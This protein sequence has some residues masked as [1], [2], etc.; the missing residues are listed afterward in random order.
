MEEA[1]ALEI[2]RATR[3]GA[4]LSLV[5]C[6]VDHFKRFND[7]FGHDAGDAVLQAV[8]AEMGRYFRDGD[9]VCR[10][11]GEE[12]TIIAPGAT[13]EQLAERI[14]ELRVAMTE[15]SVRQGGRQLGA[16]SMSFG[17]AGWDHRMARDGSALVRLADT[18]LYRAKQEGRNRTVVEM[19]QAA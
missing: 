7:D 6:D 2:A 4:P 15:L 10:Y 19:R 13:P 16:I 12:F 14:E 8:S 5:M 1:L 11:G 18:G 17:I 9:V 3:S